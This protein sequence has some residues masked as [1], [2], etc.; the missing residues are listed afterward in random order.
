MNKFPNK[1]SIKIVLHLQESETLTVQNQSL[2]TEIHKLEQEKVRLMQVLSGHENIC[3]Q[4]LQQDPVAIKTEGLS[5]VDNE[6]LAA[7][8]STVPPPQLSHSPGLLT[9]GNNFM[10]PPY[11]EATVTPVT[12]PLMTNNQNITQDTIPTPFNMS[13][14]NHSNLQSLV[15]PNSVGAISSPNGQPPSFEDAVRIATEIKM[16]DNSQDLQNYNHRQQQGFPPMYDSE[17]SSLQPPPIN[18]SSNDVFRG[19]ATFGNQIMSDSSNYFLAKRPLGHTYLD[20]DSRCIA[21]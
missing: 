14:T 17:P 2:K 11:T 20:L 10:L 1:H 16:E 6:F 3:L 18:E 12:Q 7:S 9:G 13:Q 4:R 21:L 5:P 19:T 15:P 8:T